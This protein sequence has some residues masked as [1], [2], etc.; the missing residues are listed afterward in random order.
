[1]NNHDAIATLGTPSVELC[2]SSWVAGK[3]VTQGSG[4]ALRRRR[5]I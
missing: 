5:R 2:F 4:T 3:V 1:M